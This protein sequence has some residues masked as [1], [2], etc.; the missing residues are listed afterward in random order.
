[1]KDD[2]GPSERWEPGPRAGGMGGASWDTDRGAD[3]TDLPEAERG[4]GAPVDGYDGPPNVG[5][6]LLNGS[7]GKDG[8]GIEEGPDGIRKLAP[9]GGKTPTDGPLDEW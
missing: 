3:W 6:E 1:M 9:R 5:S 4:R 8:G 2:G 7:C